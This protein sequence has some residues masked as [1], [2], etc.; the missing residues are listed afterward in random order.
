M[1]RDGD[2]IKSRIVAIVRR[3]GEIDAN[4][5][6]E[7]L[8]QHH[9]IKPKRSVLKTHIYQLRKMDYKIHA[10]QSERRQWS[11]YWGQKMRPRSKLASI[12][13]KRIK[14]GIVYGYAFRKNT[15]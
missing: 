8:Y 13:P 14:R 2:A 7:L 9:R 1:P 12:E 4:E 11:Y 5:L 6:F 3:S 15:E 10:S